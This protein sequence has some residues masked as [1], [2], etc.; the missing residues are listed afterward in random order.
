MHEVEASFISVFRPESI[1]FFFFTLNPALI[2]PC[3]DGGTLGKPPNSS[4]I[5]FFGPKPTLV[6]YKTNLKMASKTQWNCQIKGGFSEAF[7]S[8]SDHGGQRRGLHYYL[9]ALYKRLSDRKKALWIITTTSYVVLKYVVHE[10]S[11]SEMLIYSTCRKSNHALL[12]WI[13]LHSCHRTM[14]RRS[15]TFWVIE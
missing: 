4:F 6:G 9:G 1:I 11:F 5:Q 14:F 12:Q 7:F 10:G 15:D 2:K 13:M 8:K 3:P